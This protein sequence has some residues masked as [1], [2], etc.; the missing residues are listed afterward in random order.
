ML[1][2]VLTFGESGSRGPNELPFVLRSG[3]EEEDLSEFS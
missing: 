3:V 2:E 1:R